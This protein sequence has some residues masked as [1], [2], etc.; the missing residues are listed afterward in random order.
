V[1]SILNLLVACPAHAQAPAPGGFR[2]LEL[3]DA[4]TGQAFPTRGLSP[5]RLFFS[6]A[7]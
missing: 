5:Y 2:Q 1:L 6:H 7:R 4:A 3:P